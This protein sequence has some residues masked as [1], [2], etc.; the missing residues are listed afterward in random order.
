MYFQQSSFK[1]DK[2]RNDRFYAWKHCIELVLSF[3]EFEEFIEDEP[4]SFV[5]SD[6]LVWN[7][8]DGKEKAIISLSLS[9]YHL[10][11][12]NTH[13]MSKIFGFW[14]LIYFKSTP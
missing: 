3:R 10:E 9:E 14:S 5:S 11:N 4:L 8:S 7:K 6:Y 13:R 12:F 1:I 2:L